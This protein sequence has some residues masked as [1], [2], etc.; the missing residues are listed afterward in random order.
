MH[1]EHFNR[2]GFRHKKHTL[3][4]PSYNSGV[5]N[6]VN[7]NHTL[8]L[9]ILTYIRGDNYNCNHTLRLFIPTGEWQ[10]Q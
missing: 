4:I 9:F 1:R 2:L 10:L 6:T 3:F 8:Q 5:T 7:C